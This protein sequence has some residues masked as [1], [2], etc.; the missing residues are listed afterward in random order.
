LGT[1]A[2]TIPADARRAENLLEHG[3]IDMVVPRSKLR[4]T[5]SL[6]LSLAAPLGKSA[7][8]PDVKLRRVVKNSLPAAAVVSLARDPRR[9][10][11]S[12]YIQRLFTAFVELHGDRS[13]R[14][15]PAIIGGFAVFHGKTVLIVAQ[16]GGI[17]PFP[18]AYRKTRRLMSLAGKF[19]LPVIA[20]VDTPGAHPGLEAE[21][22]G[23]AI[24]IAECMAAF[25][26]ANVPIVSVVIGEGGSGGALALGIADAVLMQ[27]NAI[28]SVIS[29][30]GAAAILLQDATKS[31]ELS[32]ALKLCAK[33]LLELGIID[34][35]VPEPPGGA[36][37]DPDGAAHLLGD[38]LIY[39]LARVLKIKT[40]KLVA[41]R[42][43]RFRSMGKFERGWSRMARSLMERVRPESQETQ[44]SDTKP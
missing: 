27:E 5:L 25:A 20:F 34:D 4:S 19:R 22:R 12:D 14:D 6:L 26:K 18:E 41:R 42:W 16:Q 9:P 37:L 8:L 3:L 10:H 44:A 32:A 33:D 23:T 11:A 24:A 39:H 35:I 17:M 21:Y 28:Y 29:P 13:Y 7:D 40:R 38:R 43:E 2:E 30:E 31:S 15:D 36:H 1:I